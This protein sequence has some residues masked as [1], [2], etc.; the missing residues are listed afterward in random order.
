MCKNKPNLVD[1][2]LTSN[3]IFSFRI[4]DVGMAI[5]VFQLSWENQY[6]LENCYPKHFGNMLRT[7]IIVQ[8]YLC[9]NIYW[10]ISQIKWKETPTFYCCC[11]CWNRLFIAEAN[12]FT[13]TY[14]AIDPCANLACA[15]L[16]KPVY[17]PCADDKEKAC[18]N[19]AWVIIIKLVL[20][21]NN[22]TS[23]NFG[24]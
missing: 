9:N 18:F 20:T 14:N 10:D 4:W 6:D 22:F 5:S 23:A 7:T 17:S 24:Y 13:V 15:G 21:W 16:N 1:Y 3:A 11:L 12:Q 8:Q 2:L 19:L